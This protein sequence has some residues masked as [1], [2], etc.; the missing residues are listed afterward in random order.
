IEILTR[1]GRVAGVRLEG[2]ETLSA[3]V[4]I[5]DV[6]PGALAALAGNALP[7]RFLRALRRYRPGPATLKV[8][9][10]LDGPIPWSAPEARGAGTV[11]VGGS[12]AEM[13]DITAGG[14]RL[15][16]QPFL[17]VGQ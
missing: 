12:E 7:E 5:A 10:A 15:P 1:D 2:G 4:V 13:L 17:L 9:W 6:M 14:R 11:H 3:S 8:D 16:E